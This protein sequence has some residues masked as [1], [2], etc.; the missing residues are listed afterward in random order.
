[1]AIEFYNVKKKAK[2]QINESECWKVTY[3]T[4]LKSGKKQT[5]YAVKATDDGV[6]L[7]K[8][9][10]EDTWKSCSVPEK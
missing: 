6:N 7:T 2:V 1:M 9:V 4:T 5:R 8:F 3:N 10:S